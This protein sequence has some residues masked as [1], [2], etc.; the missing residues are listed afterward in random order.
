VLWPNE[1]Q[2]IFLPGE[3]IGRTDANGQPIIAQTPHLEET[4]SADLA[5]TVDNYRSLQPLQ[6]RTFRYKITL[7]TR[8]ELTDMGVTFKAPHHGRGR[9][10]GS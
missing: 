10:G 7:P 5:N 9:T 4:L 6:P 1:L 3:S 2:K 8:Q